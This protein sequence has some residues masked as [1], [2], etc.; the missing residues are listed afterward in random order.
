[1]DNTSQSLYQDESRAV[2]ITILDQNHTAFVPTSASTYK[3]TD[4][5]GVEVISEINAT[6]SS[7]TLTAVIGTAVTATVGNYYIIWS[8]VDSNGYIYKHKTF[9]QVIDLEAV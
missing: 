7:N 1:V 3:V 5:G 6:N 4:D 8:I 2:I 9:I